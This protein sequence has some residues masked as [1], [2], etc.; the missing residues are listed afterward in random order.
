MHGGHYE[1]VQLTGVLQVYS[2]Q[3]YNIANVHSLLAEL[4]VS[5][6]LVEWEL[7]E[8]LQHCVAQVLTRMQRLR[9]CF[10]NFAPSDNKC[11]LIVLL[12]TTGKTVWRQPWKVL[13]G[14][15]AAMHSKDQNS[16]PIAKEKLN[17]SEPEMGKSCI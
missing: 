10:P 8:L 3:Q 17:V 16:T 9:K 4:T 11:V 14:Q 6:N 15:Q 5:E 7:T 1:R 2:L 12:L 13:L